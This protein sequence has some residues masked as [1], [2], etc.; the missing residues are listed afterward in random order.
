VAATLAMSALVAC[1][2]GQPG[3]SPLTFAVSFPTELSQAALDGRIILLISNNDE[4]EPRFQFPVYQA[5]PDMQQAFGINVDGLEPGEDAVI[6]RTV[7]GFPRESIDDIPPG[8]YW[9]QAVLHKYETFN[10]ADGHTVKLPM[11]RGEGLDW[12]SAPGNLYSTPAQIRIDPARDQVIR[13]SL[14]QEIP[15]FPEYQDTDYIKHV[16][17]QSEL[18][19][20]FWGRPMH[21]GAIVL[22]PEGFDEHPDARYP[23]VIN[24]GHFSREF[25]ANGGFSEDPP[26]AGLEG[27]ARIQ[28]E[29]RYQFFRDWT[30]GGFPRVILLQIQHPNPY[31][32]DSYAVNSANMGPYG[33]AITHELIPFVEE[34]FQAIGQPWARVLFGGSTGGWEA[35]GVQVMYP[36]DYNG[37]WALCPDPIDF[38]GY[39][40]VNIYDDENAYYYSSYW[41]RTPRPGYRNYLGQ[42]SSTFEERNFAELVVGTRGRSGGQ[43]DAWQAVFSPVD[44]DGY[45]APIYDKRTGEMDPEVAEYWRQNYDL[46]HIMER[47]WAT[48]GPKLVGKIRIYIGDMDNGYLNNAVYWTE[49]FL[50]STTDPYYDGIVEYGDRFEHCWTGDHDNPN[51]VA[52][53]TVVQRF[54]PAMIQRMVGTA[55]QGADLRSWRY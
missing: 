6:D 49:E 45:P 34:T 1:G 11:D 15:P 31:F 13:V 52:R 10:R 37:T 2:G 46:H 8:E 20:E 24:H 19:T 39:R 54:L 28:A 33:D 29:G 47:D 3:G 17:I 53:H 42:I 27:N 14:D 25:T 30:S 4:Q 35:L 55:P 7:F 40:L 16:Q 43:H 21:L 22:L 26:E 36:D 44:D 18:L 48:L 41:K 5:G 32:D 51:N 38:H 23:L 9:I 50:E 12:T